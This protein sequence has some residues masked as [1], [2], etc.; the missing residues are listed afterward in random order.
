MI[1]LL[2]KCHFCYIL[3]TSCPKICDTDCMTSYPLA[4]RHAVK[5]NTEVKASRRIRNTTHL[6]TSFL[7][8]YRDSYSKLLQIRAPFPS[9]FHLPRLFLVSPPPLPHLFPSPRVSRHRIW[10]NKS[11]NVTL[12]QMFMAFFKRIKTF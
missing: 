9:S 4:P 3:Q 12:K 2:K 1:W 7:G 10:E 5:Y 8:L 11:S 6:V